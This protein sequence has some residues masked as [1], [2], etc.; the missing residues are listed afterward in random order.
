MRYSD[1]N[2]R[3]NLA[4]MVSNENLLPKAQDEDG[5]S[6]RNAR[7]IE[8]I[9]PFVRELRHHLAVVKDRSCD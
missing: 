7:P 1:E 6:N 4:V 3:S 2:R 9:G 5:E 8:T